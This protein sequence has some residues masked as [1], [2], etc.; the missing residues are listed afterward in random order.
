[1]PNSSLTF[2]IIAPAHAYVA[3]TNSRYAGVTAPA[4]NSPANYHHLLK[5]LLD[6]SVSLLLLAL[7]LPIWLIT[8][9]AIKWE[10][11]GAVFFQQRRTGLFNQEFNILKFRSMC[12]DAEKDGA[13]WASKNDSRITRVGKF[14]RK[15]RIDELPQLLNVLKGEMSMVGPRPE[16]EVFIRDLEK[17]IPFYRVRH[18]VKPGVT[19]LAQVSYTYGAS[20]EDAKHKH[21]YDMAYIRH[22]SVWMD[23]RILWNTV[24]VVLTGQGV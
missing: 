23:L 17:H 2:R 9:I 14:I 15:T 18:T 20:L 11:P 6:V 5:R 4:V 1:M 19:G 24:R 13:R 7:T 10:S 22:Q 8:A 21:R 12:E 3:A 16:R